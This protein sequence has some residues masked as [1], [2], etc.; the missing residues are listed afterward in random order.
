MSNYLPATLGFV[1]MLMASAALANDVSVPSA[2]SDSRT[3][4]W[5]PNPMESAMKEEISVV[6]GSAREGDAIDFVALNREGLSRLPL[7]DPGTKTSEM[8]S[9]QTVGLPGPHLSL[10][11]VDDEEPMRSMQKDVSEW[12][13]AYRWP[14][15]PP[16]GSPPGA[17]GG[18]GAPP[19]TTTGGPYIAPTSPSDNELLQELN[20]RAE[21]LRDQIRAPGQK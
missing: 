2:G 15:P 10:A 12:V 3:A 1:A 8:Y 18:F 16:P 19:L 17:I 20:R 5:G 9:I 14:D 21:Q 6:G 7:A 13:A 11:I 4:Q